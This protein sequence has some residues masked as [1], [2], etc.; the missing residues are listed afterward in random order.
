MV[1]NYKTQVIFGSVTS[2]YKGSILIPEGTKFSKEGVNSVIKSGL[3]TGA[4]Q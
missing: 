3:L 1:I 4:T 2:F